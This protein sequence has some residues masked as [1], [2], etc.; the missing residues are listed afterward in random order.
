M[1]QHIDVF[2][3][4]S[5]MHQNKMKYVRCTDG[6]RRGM[7]MWQ[8]GYNKMLTFNSTAGRYIGDQCKILL[9]LLY[10]WK[11]LIKY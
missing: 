9:A 5:E 10:V 4:Y 11:F 1:G 8:S 7:D 3:I 2:V 6:Q